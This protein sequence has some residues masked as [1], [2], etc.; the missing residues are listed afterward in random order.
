[1]YKAIKETAARIKAGAAPGLTIHIM[2]KKHGVSRHQ[3]ASQ[4]GKRGA[5]TR[6]AQ[7]SSPKQLSFDFR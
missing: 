2:A 3:L 1:M 5:R 7:E 4:L 6:K